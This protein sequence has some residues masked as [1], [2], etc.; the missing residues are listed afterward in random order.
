LVGAGRGKGLREVCHGG[1][2]NNLSVVWSHH[3]GGRFFPVWI[4]QPPA[5]SSCLG[6][7]LGAGPVPGAQKTGMWPT[8][9]SAI[10][11]EKRALER[12]GFWYGETTH[13][14]SNGPPRP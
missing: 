11:G 7:G 6:E 3:G 9:G 8:G 10:G 12:E 4:R 5:F 2:F 13:S 1:T 14:R